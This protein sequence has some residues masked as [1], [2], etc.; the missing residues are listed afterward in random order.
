MN[1][2]ILYIGEMELPDKNASSH[3][4]LAN[5]KIISEVTLC[6]VIIIGLNSSLEDRPGFKITDSCY[7]LGKFTIYEYP[8]PK[9]PMQW[10][11]YITRIDYIKTIVN[12]IGINKICAIVAYNYPAIALEQLRQ[13][14]KRNNIIIISDATEWYG[15]S[16][17][18]FPSN[19]IK[20]FD[21]FLR[22]R[23]INKRCYNVI[24]ASNYLV[25]YYK[26]KGCNTLNIPSLVDNTDR[27]YAVEK[28]QFDR[29][30]KIY[31]YV[32]SPGKSREKDRLDWIINSFYKLKHEGY[33]FKVIF[34]GVDQES[35]LRYYPELGRGVKELNDCL[36]FKGRVVHSAAIEIISNSDFSLFA[37]EIN[38]VTLAGF[39]TKLAESYACHTPVITTPS[40]NVRE[41]IINEKT[42]FVSKTCDEISFY[43]AVLQS[44]VLDNEHVKYM[45][46]Y[47]Q[48][49]NPMN[50]NNFYTKS[51]SYFQK[52]LQIED[53]ICYT[54]R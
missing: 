14:C 29:E 51:K 6:D 43:E 41:Y 24:C 54:N 16:K 46:E 12:H 10:F 36:E 31:S 25:D 52:L 15:K 40:S 26:S 3:R 48:N 5:S 19:M 9:T 23:H 45:K 30:F 28:R 49:N 8:Y 7:H 13:F 37:R 34:A 11:K 32:G 35:L 21:T 22:M 18:T 47:I 1:Q 42:G 33:K 38:R 27:K 17:R 2:Y 39:P 20:D 44:I 53:S 50:V 4:V